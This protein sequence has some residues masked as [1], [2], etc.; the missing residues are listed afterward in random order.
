M[1]NIIKI[2]FMCSLLAAL[3]SCRNFSQFQERENMTIY[4]D[5]KIIELS[6]GGFG[7]EGKAEPFERLS[8][9][10]IKKH[11][12]YRLYND[13]AN[14]NEAESRIKNYGGNIRGVFSIK[15]IGSS[16]DW[17]TVIRIVSPQ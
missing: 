4:L 3:S 2:L 11:V 5:G 10:T 12:R 16:K 14:K 8:V 9:R 17:S 13:I 6:D 15:K 7:I 1:K